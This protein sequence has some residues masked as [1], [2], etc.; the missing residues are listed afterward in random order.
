MPA[1]K[2]PDYDSTDVDKALKRETQDGSG[3]ENESE[4]PES[5]FVSLGDEVEN[6]H[7]GDNDPAVEGH[8]EEE[9]EV[10]K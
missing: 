4:L 3:F 5:D 9:T 2:Q 1:A 10:S 6:N 7:D 8:D